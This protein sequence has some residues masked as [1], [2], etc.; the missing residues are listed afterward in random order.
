MSLQEWVEQLPESHRARQE[1]AALSQQ[2]GVPEVWVRID[3]RSPPR[4]ETV[5]YWHKSQYG[6]FPAI[7]DEWRDE[8]HF[9]FATHW[10]PGASAAPQPGKED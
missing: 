7:A 6:G 10:H 2:P 3:E 9:R 4:N 8:D 5:V 1:F